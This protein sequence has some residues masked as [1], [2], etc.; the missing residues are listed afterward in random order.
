[1]DGDMQYKSMQTRPMRSLVPVARPGRPNGST[2]PPGQFRDLPS[3]PEATPRTHPRSGAPDPGTRSYKDEKGDESKLACGQLYA[4]SDP[5][6]IETSWSRM[7]LYLHYAIAAVTGSGRWA[8]S[9][10]PRGHWLTQKV[11]TLASQQQ[12]N[13]FG[14]NLDCAAKHQQSCLYEVSDPIYT[15]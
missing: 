14:R 2:K 4:L 8:D 5:I 3:L 11:E 10:M 6:T 13:M 7:A 12:V 1:V 9:R 15:P